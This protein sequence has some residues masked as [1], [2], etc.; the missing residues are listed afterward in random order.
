LYVIVC[1]EKNF[2]NAR[3]H[4]WTDTKS[5]ANTSRR[6][7]KKMLGTSERKT[8]PDVASSAEESDVVATPMCLGDD[9]EMLVAKKEVKDGVK[10]KAAYPD[11]EQKRELQTEM[12]AD[13]EL[14]CRFAFPY[15]RRKTSVHVP[16]LSGVDRKTELI[17]G[18]VASTKD[19][20]VASTNDADVILE[21]KEIVLPSNAS[22][23]LRRMVNEM[24]V[25]AG[26]YRAYDHPCQMTSVS[27]QSVHERLCRGTGGDLDERAADFWCAV[28]VVLRF[29]LPMRRHTDPWN[30]PELG[31]RRQHWH[32]R[33]H[34]PRVPES[35]ALA[36]P[37]E[38]AYALS[39]DVPDSWFP[40]YLNSS[41]TNIR[42]ALTMSEDTPSD[43]DVGERIESFFPLMSG[44]FVNLYEPWQREPWRD[45]FW[46]HLETVA[47]ANLP[48]RR[49]SLDRGSVDPYAIGAP[50]AISPNLER[51]IAALDVDSDF[52][53]SKK[54]AST[55]S[56][57]NERRQNPAEPSTYGEHGDY[58]RFWRAIR[59]ATHYELPMERV[60]PW[61]RAGTATARHYRDDYRGICLQ[62]P[63]SA[64][65]AELAYA[66]TIDM[67]NGDYP[68]NHHWG[69]DIDPRFAIN[70][71]VWNNLKS[72][73]SNDSS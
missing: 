62:A 65:P 49:R 66:Y 17:G 11:A 63:G 19:V 58:G 45:T 27:P 41:T 68:H 25:D 64:S 44:Q 33:L 56:I 15:V 46:R 54:H 20:D 52:Y 13:L 37:T 36:G 40:A 61:T 16:V 32:T 14:V 43:R 26:F 35:C 71:T 1:H 34:V 48:F 9:H 22:D 51:M 7:T 24:Q 2:L 42:H 53:D 21:C 23:E 39:L 29:G 18:T 5:R 10:E 38:V 60:D 28:R 8:K 67:S 47:S 6:A 30:S 69:Y 12:W 55:L 4:G 70:P 72:V 57:V 3:Q 31:P 50:R 59:I 73:E